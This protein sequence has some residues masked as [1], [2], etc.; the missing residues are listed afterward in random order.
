MNS[1]FFEIKDIYKNFDE[2]TALSSISLDIIK[3]EIFGIVGPDGSGKTTL[4]RILAGILPFDSGNLKITG[5]EIKDSLSKIGYMPQ[6]FAL[7]PD[8]TLIENIM[9]YSEIY[10]VDKEN[11]E[12][13]IK[14]LLTSF[15]IYDFKN[16]KA[17]KLSGGMKQKLALA[18]TLIHKPDILILDEPT[19][20]VDPVSRREFWNIL[21]ELREK[22]VTIITST[23][24][25][26][27]AERCSHVAFLYKGKVLSVDTVTNLKQIKDNKMYYITNENARKIYYDLIKNLGVPDL[28]LTGNSI[29]IFLNNNEKSDVLQKLEN[30][31]ISNYKQNLKFKI[32][33]PLLEDIFHYLVGLEEKNEL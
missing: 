27:E 10:G 1:I 8:L 20:G 13:T 33:I 5:N 24:Y 12:K 23:S 17:G 14:D 28:N 4:L 30:Y 3:G 29:K 15:S 6:R 9:F 11:Q 26:E 16:R 22:K 32:G 31:L 19:N 7:Y 2:K 18:C 25:L 21:Y